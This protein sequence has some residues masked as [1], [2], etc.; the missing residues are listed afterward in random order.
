MPGRRRPKPKDDD[1]APVRWFRQKRAER[2]REKWHQK[3]PRYEPFPRLPAF[4]D[5]ELERVLQAAPEG[6]WTTA[7]LLAELHREGARMSRRTL[8]RRLAELEAS[9]PSY[10]R[11]ASRSGVVSD[12]LITLSWAETTGETA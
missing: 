12:P 5:R 11:W 1:K 2:R 9:R 3:H 7:G 4:W 6:G 10:G 8:Y